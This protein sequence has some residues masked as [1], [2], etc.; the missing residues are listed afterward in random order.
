MWICINQ[1]CLSMLVALCLLCDNRDLHQQESQ[2]NQQYKI[3]IRN[4][5]AWGEQATSENAS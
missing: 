5:I 4:Q 2:S 3:A 1:H